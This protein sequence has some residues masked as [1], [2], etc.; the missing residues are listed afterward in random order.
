MGKQKGQPK[1]GGREKGTPNKVT[2]DLRTWLSDLWN[3][4]REQFEKDLKALEPHQRVASFEKLLNYIIPKQQ[5]VEATIESID[6]RSLSDEQLNL[7]IN[8]ITNDL[9]DEN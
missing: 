3:G 4:N 9:S 6:L 1:T 7:I 8:R 5:S 2:S